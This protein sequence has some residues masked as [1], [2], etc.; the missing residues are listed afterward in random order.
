M[1]AAVL[2]RT[3]GFLRAEAK[4]SFSDGTQYKTTEEL[5]TNN[6]IDLDLAEEQ[7]IFYREH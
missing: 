4:Q 1:Y 2:Q 3:K 7:I 5:M 6:E